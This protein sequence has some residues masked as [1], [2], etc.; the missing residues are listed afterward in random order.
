MTLSTTTPD[1]WSGEDILFTM[2]VVNDTTAIQLAGVLDSSTLKIGGGDKDGSA[3]VLGNGGRAWKQDP[4]KEV[5]VEFDAYTRGIQ[6]ENGA[7]VDMIGFEQFFD[8]QTENTTDVLSST[9]TRTQKKFRLALLKTEDTSATSAA[10]ASATSKAAKRFI[11]AN[12]R[13][14]KHEETYADYVWKVSVS[15]KVPP[16]KLGAT[17]NIKRESTDGSGTTGLAALSAYTDTTN[18]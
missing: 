16:F 10:G 13:M 2:H 6:T 7:T 12:A 15:F 8:G 1:V 18:W 5:T 11:V 17:S 4:Q 9:N 14:V 3:I